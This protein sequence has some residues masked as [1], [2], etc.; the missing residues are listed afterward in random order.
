MKSIILLSFAIFLF[1]SSVFSQEKELTPEERH[2][3]LKAKKVAVITE[4]LDLSVEEA[5]EFWPVYN[6]LEKKVEAINNQ[7]KEYHEKIKL[8]LDELSNSEKEEIA[9]A[10][11]DTDI[12]EAN[13]KMEY[14]NRYKKILPIDKVIRLYQTEHQFKRELIRELK[15][16]RGQ[17]QGNGYGHRHGAP[18]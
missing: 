9:D 11:V 13:L 2:A 16:P 1:G 14:H 10:M 7:R 6:E 4:R 12:Q 5:Q 18:N 8:H 3:K 17:G 15:G